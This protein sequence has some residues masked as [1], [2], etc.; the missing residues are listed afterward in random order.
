MEEFLISNQIPRRLLRVLQ[1]LE[2]YN[3]YIIQLLKVLLHIINPH[4]PRCF[5]S[6]L[7]KLTIH[8]RSLLLQL[9]V[10]I[11]LPTFILVLLE[12][13]VHVLRFIIFIMSLKLSSY[14]GVFRV[15]L[16]QLLDEFL[17]EIVGH[18][19]EFV[20]VCV[21]LLYLVLELSDL[22]NTRF[23]HVFDLV[24]VVFSGLVPLFV[25]VLD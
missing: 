19:F 18:P 3:K 1:L 5:K 2:L 17:L 10:Y 8:I 9:L 21:Y 12:D 24:D 20:D 23:Q 25:L 22:V 11:L 4:L 14:T 15:G 13:G 16:A 7:F 6:N